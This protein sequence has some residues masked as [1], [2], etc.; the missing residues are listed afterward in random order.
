MTTQKAI[1]LFHAQIQMYA[2]V[3]EYLESGVT[4]RCNACAHGF[5]VF[6]NGIEFY[7]VGDYAYSQIPTFAYCAISIMRE[8]A[9]GSIKTAE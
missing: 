5:D 3:H 7:H 1:D 6:I 4:L 2:T 9:M 8:F